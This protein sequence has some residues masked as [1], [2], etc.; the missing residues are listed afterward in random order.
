[1]Y[2][3]A[4]IC[5][6]LQDPSSSPTTIRLETPKKNKRA[7]CSPG[8]GTPQ[9][10]IPRFTS[11]IMSLQM[12]LVDVFAGNKDIVPTKSDLI[13]MDL[14]SNTSMFKAG[15]V[16]SDPV[17]KEVQKEVQIPT[18][19]NQ[20]KDVEESE[21]GQIME[22]ESQ[23]SPANEAIAHTAIID[24]IKEAV[25]LAMSPLQDEITGLT[26]T[27][28]KM[29]PLKE[30]VKSLKDMINEL[31]NKLTHQPQVAKDSSVSPGIP[32]QQFQFPSTDIREGFLVAQKQ[33]NK[34]VDM[35]I[36]KKKSYSQS[37]GTYSNLTK[38]AR[39]SP[40]PVLVLQPPPLERINNK[41]K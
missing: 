3:N 13:N 5:A 41:K 21:E 35:L 18:S 39:P 30:E 14:M 17:Q 22:D 15:T 24:L 4:P 40:N 33:T 6:G 29:L 25:R 20:K 34:G 7:A 1:M 2:P 38:S 37:L 36:R 10:R 12:E 31:K 9:P 26:N 32:D 16:I 27:V 19:N 11:P 8:E 28:S 23:R